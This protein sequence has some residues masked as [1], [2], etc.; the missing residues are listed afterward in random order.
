MK[1]IPQAVPYL[2]STGVPGDENAQFVI[3]C[4]QAILCESKSLR[5]AI[6]N[7]VAAYYIFDMA[8]PKGAGG[9]LYFFQHY[10][11]S[12]KD[13]SPLPTC[14]VKL[15]YNLTKVS[16]CVT[17]CVSCILIASFKHVLQRVWP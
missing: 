12:I 11:F 1:K 7:L 6:V 4:E 13:S 17:L 2:V 9:I 16:A 10:V 14:T 5:D 3:A 8:Y 15:V